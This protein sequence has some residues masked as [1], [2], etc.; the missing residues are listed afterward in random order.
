M[1]RNVWLCDSEQPLKI[2]C[3]IDHLGSGGA[4]RQL[5]NLAIGLR[6]K[7]HEVEFFAYHAGF[8]FFAEML[9]QH[10]IPLTL[11]SNTHPIRVV[12]ALTHLIHSRKPDALI[13]FLQTPNLYSCVARISRPKTRLIASERN[14]HLDDKGAVAALIKRLFL[15]VADVVVTNSNAHAEWLRHHFWLRDK[16]RVAYNGYQIPDEAP[17][18]PIQ[19]PDHLRLIGIGR[20]QPQKNLIK[21]V[22]ALALF[23]RTHGYCPEVHWVGYLDR[24]PQYS[25]YLEQVEE[26]LVQHPAVRKTWHWLGERRDINDLLADSDAMILPSLYEG[27]PNAV[28]EALA[29]GRPVLTSDVCDNSRLIEDGT[30]GFL[31]NPHSVD[32]IVNA[33]E[34]FVALSYAERNFMAHSCY[35]F[36]KTTLTIARMTEQYCEIIESL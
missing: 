8:Q 17:P 5:V 3:V 28:C 29:R 16:T 32:S 4:Q 10:H 12:G 7:G 25:T 31:F 1:P 35:E 13:S 15:S 23:E 2:L 19:R 18:R 33:I 36:A 9:N 26:R 20:V 30:R 34:R 6:Q 11:A 14:S 24:R 21:L 22:D 27:M